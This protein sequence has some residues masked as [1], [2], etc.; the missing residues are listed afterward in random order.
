M[1][2]HSCEGSLSSL[3]LPILLQHFSPVGLSFA[4][5]LLTALQAGAEGSREGGDEVG[6]GDLQH[7]RHHRS[8]HAGMPPPPPLLLPLQAGHL[9]GDCHLPPRWRSPQSSS[10]SVST[11]LSVTR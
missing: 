8:L 9:Q 11:A 4:P 7:P 10:A 2:G 3:L 5:A 6:H 1:G